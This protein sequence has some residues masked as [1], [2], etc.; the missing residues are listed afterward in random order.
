M[1]IDDSSIVAELKARPT[2]LQQICEA[3]KSDSELIT[4]R[5]QIEKTPDSEF[6][7][8][9]KGSLYFQNRI[10]VLRNSDVIQKILQ[11]AH[12]SSFSIH[13]GSNKMYSDLKQMY[14]WPGMKREISEFV[15]K[16]Y[17]DYFRYEKLS[18]RYLLDYY[19]L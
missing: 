19:S 10:C 7:V 14:W 11:E 13:P 6:H 3:Q 9:S 4:K 18:M 17:L 2:F 12:S 8:S 1:L 5:E 16:C 15:S